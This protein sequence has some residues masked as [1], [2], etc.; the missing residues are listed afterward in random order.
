MQAF[1]AA[2]QQAEAQITALKETRD[3]HAVRPIVS[4]LPVGDSDGAAVEQQNPSSERLHVTTLDEKHTVSATPHPIVQT[5]SS[6]PAPM[7]PGAIAVPSRPG[8]ARGLQ[9]TQEQG[10][11]LLAAAAS[12]SALREENEVGSTSSLVQAPYYLDAI[13]PIP[14]LISWGC[15][16]SQVLRQYRDGVITQAVARWSSNDFTQ[17]VTDQNGESRHDPHDRSQRQEPARSRLA[18]AAAAAAAAASLDHQSGVQGADREMPST[19]YA[20]QKIEVDENGGGH[21]IMA[22]LK[23]E[24]RRVADLQS[25]I[26]ARDMALGRLRATVARLTRALA[27]IHHTVN[28]QAQR[29]AVGAQQSKAAESTVSIK[30]RAGSGK[31]GTARSS[32]HVSRDKASRDAARAPPLVTDQTL[33]VLSEALAEPADQQGTR[34]RGRKQDSVMADVVGRDQSSVDHGFKEVSVRDAEA[35]SLEISDCRLQHAAALAQV[36]VCASVCVNYFFDVV[37]I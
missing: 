6:V 36:C 23:E 13:R 16:I 34:K 4:K 35:V 20:D 22:H 18:A 26:A 3:D 30:G 19:D 24:Q 11:G 33:S 28:V 37:L 25:G 9:P 10:W 5:S 2:L 29:A 31:A 32:K 8:Q 27:R 17:H 7:V 14:L 15:A 21:Y 1:Q 12:I